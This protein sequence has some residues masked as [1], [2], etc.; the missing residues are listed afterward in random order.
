MKQK[1]MK[2]IGLVLI[3]GMMSIALMACGSSD[4][5]GT[6][7]Q[8]NNGSGETGTQEEFTFAMSGLYPPF[9]Y[10]DN[11]ELVGFD[12][13][14][15]YALA[16]KMGMS[17][18]PVTNPWQT[19]LAALQ[20]NRFDAI[21]GS[22]AITEE[23]QKEVNFSDPYY[24]SGAQVFVKADNEEISSADDINGK[25]IGVVV[26]STFEDI[27]KEYTD[28]VSTYDSDV[29]A[30]QDLLVN[31]RIDAVITDQLV[32][33]YAINQNNLAIKPVGEPLF[34]DQMGIPVTKENTELLEKIN[35][36][37]KEIKEDG[38]YAEIS[39]RYFGVDIS[40]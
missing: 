14:I 25:K 24:E 36:A 39:A 3:G 30:L 35:A 31:G 1:V 16:E 28:H 26:S 34:L 20:S 29:T 27:A 2:K 33:M 23:R 32:G 13:E 9:N 6:E 10:N 19:I 22:M 11:G 18:N 12:V 7:S 38:T 21:I 8:G 17:P 5:G 15:G 4:T 37:L 40:E